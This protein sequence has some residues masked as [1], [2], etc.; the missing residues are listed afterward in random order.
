MKRRGL[1]G[2]AAIGAVATLALAACGGGSSSSGGGGGGSSSGSAGFNAATTG[3][4]NPS[5]HKGGTLTFKGDLVIQQ[6]SASAERS[7]HPS[8]PAPHSLFPR[9]HRFESTVV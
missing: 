7:R 9:A 2:L 8:A 6:N 5:S 3:V 4:V 1:T